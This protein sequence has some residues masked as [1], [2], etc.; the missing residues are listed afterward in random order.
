MEK[1]AVMM[2]GLQFTACLND[3]LSKSGKD[4]FTKDEVISFSMQ[5]SSIVADDI[6]NGIDQKRA[7]NAV[8]ELLKGESKD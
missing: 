8:D 5:A 6:K 3:L 4:V 1:M 2:I 7:D